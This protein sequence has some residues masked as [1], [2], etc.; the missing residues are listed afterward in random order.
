MGKDLK[1]SRMREI[2]LPYTSFLTN[3]TDKAVKNLNA[4]LHYTI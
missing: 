2:I 3:K 1:Y 4:L